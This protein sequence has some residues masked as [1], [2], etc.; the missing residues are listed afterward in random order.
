MAKT[1]KRNHKP[2][3]DP[4]HAGFPSTKK[5]KPSGDGRAVVIPQPKIPPP[6]TKH[7]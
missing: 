7:K 6:K 3:S 1:N 5:H 2:V 4:E